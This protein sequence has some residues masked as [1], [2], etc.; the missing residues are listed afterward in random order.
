MTVVKLLLHISLSL[1][2]I[3]CSPTPQS[4]KATGSPG[5]D[6]TTGWLHGNC[7]AIKTVDDLQGRKIAVVQLGETQKIV[8]LVLLRQAATGE[9]CFALLE[10]R[11]AVNNDNGRRF[12]IV[13][14]EIAIDLGIGVLIGNQDTV[15]DN[16]PLDSNRD[17]LK[18]TYSY[19]STSEG[20]QFSVWDGAPYKS[21]ILW[22][23]YYYLGYD[24]EA[25]CPA[26][27]I[28]AE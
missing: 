13:S 17:G 22:S 28:N 2:F 16:K 10:D 23:D 19:C 15:A 25:D 11:A 1:F 27:A 7:F 6:A 14:S 18:D 8:E 5:Q 26:E 9:E 24:S 20:V 4:D 12:Y 21:T 3:A